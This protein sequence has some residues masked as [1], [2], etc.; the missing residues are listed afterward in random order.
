MTFRERY[1]AFVAERFPFAVSVALAAFD[2]AAGKRT[3]SAPAAIDAL[4]PGLIDAL[5]GQ[6]SWPKLGGRV[7]TT[8]GVTAK[9]R[10]DQSVEALAAEVDGWLRREAIA[11]G[12][13]DAETVEIL[14]GMV[15]S[16]AVDSRLK[17]FFLGSEVKHEGKP[18][19]GKGFRSLGQE[20]IYASAIRLRRGSDWRGEGDAWRGD[21]VAPII[22]DVGAALAMRN[23]PETVRMILSAQMGKAGP[24][25]DGRDLHIGDW[26]WGILPATAPLS[27]STR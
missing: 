25:M 9:S 1:Q 6:V 23:D 14:R 22:R 8:P 16:R 19:Q 27:V 11:A 10:L 17:A 3:P 4:R 21:V 15:L 2:A 26:R 12:L 5:R 7:E 20:A 18:F 24:P 13:T